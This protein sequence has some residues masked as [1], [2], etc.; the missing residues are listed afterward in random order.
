LP[1]A[2]DE[3]RGRG[4]I[5]ARRVALWGYCTGGNLAWLAATFIAKTLDDP[6]RVA[7]QNVPLH[8]A[9]GVAQNRGVVEV[10]AG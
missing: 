9:R 7:A 5:D 2:V 6:L 1:E 10:G 3:M 4:D 8:S